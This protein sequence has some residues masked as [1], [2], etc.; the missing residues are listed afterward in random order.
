MLTLISGDVTNAEIALGNNEFENLLANLNGK[1]IEDKKKEISALKRKLKDEID[2]IPAR[3][4]ELYRSMP[5][6]IYETDINKRIDVLNNLIQNIDESIADKSKQYDEI[7][8]FNLN[9]N[10]QISEINNSIYKLK[11]ES[12]LKQQNAY[13]EENRLFYLKKNEIEKLKQQID[14][15]IFTKNLYENKISDLQK[16][17]EKLRTKFTVEDAAE[18]SFDT[19]QLTCPT[20]KRDFDDV[21]VYTKK[22]E[23]KNSFNLQKANKLKAI[24]EQGA[25]LKE[26]ITSEKEKLNT[27]ETLLTDLSVQLTELNPDPFKNQNQNIFIADTESYLT[28][29]ECVELKTKID[30]L[31]IQLKPIQDFNLQQ[32]TFQKK[33]LLEEIDTLK[34]Q[35]NNNYIAEKTKVRI[36]ELDDTIKNANQK[37][38]DLE[39][40]EF[41][42]DKFIRAKITTIETNINN[43]FSFVKFKMYNLLVNGSEEPTCETLINGVPYSSANAA[44]QKNAGIDIIN[45]LSNYY[46]VT[47]PIFLDNAESTNS[48]IDSNCQLIKLFV[49]EPCPKDNN[50]KLAYI[51]NYEFLGKLLL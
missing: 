30:N 19:I 11:Q 41:T 7:N 6:V 3:I 37:I 18:C 14:S 32:L 13:D 31:K 45:T 21:D 51:S 24:N 26:R 47:C 16:E 33:P 39:N 17:I 49:I 2:S 1:S 34:K 48:F 8:N 44:A 40:I 46:H 50:A 10:N 4:D 27:I 23:L 5:V 35:L 22:E 15:S 28:S 9:I 12:I 20:C 38:A 36:A 42:I 29:P 25:I 43:M